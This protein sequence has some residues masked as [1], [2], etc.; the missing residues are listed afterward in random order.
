MNK[1][2]AALRVGVQHRPGD[3]RQGILVAKSRNVGKSDDED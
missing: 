2:G 1:I 3:R